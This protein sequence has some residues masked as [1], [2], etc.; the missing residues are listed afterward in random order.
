MTRQFVPDPEQLRRA[1]GQIRWNVAWATALTGLAGTVA[2]SGFVPEVGRHNAVPLPVS[3]LLVALLGAAAL[4]V[5][6]SYV[7]TQL[8]R[9]RHLARR[10]RDGGAVTLHPEALE[11][12]GREPVPW[13]TI[14]TAVLHRTRSSG[15]ELTLADG[16]RIRLPA[17]EFGTTADALG[18]AFAA[19]LPVADPEAAYRRWGEY[20]NGG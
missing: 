17:V 15:L 7:T 8:L 13:R 20:L 4:A 9:S 12:P 14:R 3:P 19:Y 2:V 18:Q 5:G 11:L 6:G 16:E 1:R 10:A